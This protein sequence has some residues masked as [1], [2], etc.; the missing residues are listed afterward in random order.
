MINVSLIKLIYE[1][2]RLLMEDLTSYVLTTN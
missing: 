2:E 1:D